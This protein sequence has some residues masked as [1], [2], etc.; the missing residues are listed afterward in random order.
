MTARYIQRGDAMDYTPDHDVRAGDIVRIG[1]FTGVAKLDIK[2][3]EQ[4]AIALVGVYQVK[5]ADNV[6]IEAGGFVYFDPDTGLCWPDMPRNPKAFVLGF[7]V[8]DIEFTVPGYACV[9][10]KN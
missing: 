8:D 10:L 3:G 1:Y 7:A 2:A 9:R 4:G 5:L 6:R